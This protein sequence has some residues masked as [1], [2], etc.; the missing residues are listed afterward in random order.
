MAQ[1]MKCL[2]HKHEDLSPITSTPTSSSPIP[3]ATGQ[4]G[5]HCLLVVCSAIPIP[6]SAEL[7][8]LG[9]WLSQSKYLSPQLL[10]GTAS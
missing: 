7:V 3:L 8:T 1:W 9:P 5:A 10:A 2:S 4:L 6:S